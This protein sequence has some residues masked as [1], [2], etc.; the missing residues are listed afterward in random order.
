MIP[1]LRRHSQ[2]TSQTLLAMK[3]VSLSVEG[4]DSSLPKGIVEIRLP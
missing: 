2:K 3:E 4:N 1:L